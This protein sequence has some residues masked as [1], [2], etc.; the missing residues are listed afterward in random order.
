MHQNI[1]FIGGIHGV[2]KGTICSKIARELD[3]KHLSASDVWKWSE[4]SPDPNNK[5]VKDIPETQKR[6]IIG[7]EKAIN[8]EKKYLLD[9]HFCLFNSIGVPQK[10]SIRTFQRIAP[11]VISVITTDILEI[12]NC[13]KKRDNREYD[14]N[15]LN[16]MQISEVSYA[17]TVAEELNVP[18]FE[19]NNG[20]TSELMKF[21]SN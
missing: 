15:L 5:L 2:G 16:K 6:L 18:F 17:I 19:I 13:L 14:K 20:K 10:V 11:I 9:G 12:A 7:L 8:S 3:L 4:V 21:L 1:I